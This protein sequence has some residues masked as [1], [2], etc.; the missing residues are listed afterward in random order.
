MK[1]K[2]HPM[3]YTRKNSDLIYL[4]FRGNMSIDD[5]IKLNKH[6]TEMIEIS[7]NVNTEQ[8]KDDETNHFLFMNNE[9][10]KF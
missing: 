9:F 1:I 8:I 6:L 2:I 10:M 5:A 4:N 7:K 3:L